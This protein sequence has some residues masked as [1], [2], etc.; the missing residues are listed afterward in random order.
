MGH[1]LRRRSEQVTCVDK[2]SVNSS[3]LGNTDK[4]QVHK[5]E[6]QEQGKMNG[7]DKDKENL[8][9]EHRSPEGRDFCKEKKVVPPEE[10]LS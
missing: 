7:C 4:G 2:I 3:P 8:S 5:Q 1:N 9:W 6:P 10:R